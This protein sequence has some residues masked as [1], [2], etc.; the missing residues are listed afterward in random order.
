MKIYPLIDNDVFAL[1]PKEIQIKLINE[2][3]ANR[4]GYLPKWA[5]KLGI[6]LT[7]KKEVAMYKAIQKR[8]MY[9]YLKNEEVKDYQDNQRVLLKKRAIYTTV[10]NIT[11]SGGE[12]VGYVIPSIYSKDT[13]MVKLVSLINRTWIKI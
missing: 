12:T 10:Y 13:V 8:S 7:D 3:K 4:R 5:V 2:L 6:D 9:P 1:L 11:E